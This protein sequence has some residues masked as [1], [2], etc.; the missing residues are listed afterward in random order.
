MKKLLLVLFVSLVCV[1]FVGAQ[2]VEEEKTEILVSAAA[3]LTNCMGELSSLFMQ[4]NP[5]ITVRCNYGSSGSLQMQIEQGAPADV[6]F[7]AGI[8]Q[9]DALK[10]K[11]LMDDATVKNILE[12]KVVLIVAKDAKKLS[13]FEALSDASITKIGVGEPKSVPAGQYAAQ[14]FESLGLTDTI[15]SKLV[16]AKDVR[17]VL[18]WV[19]TENV[20][21]GVVYETDAKIS[22]GVVICAQAPEGSHKPIIYPVGVI[23]DTKHPVQ[24]KVFE[25]FL[26]TEKAK[27]VFTKYGFTALESHV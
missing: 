20:Q 19:E 26:F 10:A 6:F 27:A 13:G 9:M 3:S 8:K 11:G 12:N 18:S 24:A 14:V 17:E 5:S 1:S 4:D 22:T 21:A 7:S 25:D 2:G 16:L 15:G 23:K